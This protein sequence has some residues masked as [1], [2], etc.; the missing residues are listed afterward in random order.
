MSRR[1]IVINTL[2]GIFLVSVFAAP[3]V[4]GVAAIAYFVRFLSRLGVHEDVAFYGLVGLIGLVGCVQQ[5]RRHLWLNASF[6]VAVITLVVS[7]RYF[8]AIDP[9]LLGASSMWSIFLLFVIPRE[10]R[11][12]PWEFVL[13]FTLVATG[14]VLNAGLLGRGTLGAVVA[15]CALLITFAWIGILLRQG[16]YQTSKPDALSPTNT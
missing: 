7:G 16:R 10:D 15:D 14:F 8:D 3:F 5:W 6:S 4:A 1:E 11:L 12:R 9:L 13:G 2:L